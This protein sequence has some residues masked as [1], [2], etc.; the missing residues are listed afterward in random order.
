MDLF[1]AAAAGDAGDGGA[2]ER[3]AQA[4]RR[5]GEE[6]GASLPGEVSTNPCLA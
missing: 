2:G 6:W 5:R 1:E 4:K 3:P